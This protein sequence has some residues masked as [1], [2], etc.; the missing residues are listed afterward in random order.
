[1]IGFLNFSASG[2]KARPAYSHCDKDRCWIAWNWLL[3]EMNLD[4]Y[5]I[6]LGET[7]IKCL[8][9]T[10]FRFEGQYLLILVVMLV[11]DNV[12]P[13]EEQSCDVILCKD[14]NSWTWS[15]RV[16]KLAAIYSC[17][18]RDDWWD[19]WTW[20]L[21]DLK[22]GDR[23]LSSWRGICWNTWSKLLLHLKLAT[24]SLSLWPRWIFK[25]LKLTTVGSETPYLSAF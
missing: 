12:L 10:V 3:F 19:A 15:W 21:L 17:P 6:S 13:S 14:F 1:M 8:N 2:S 25:S 23:S 7:R 22:L 11:N 4:L 9:L 18:D 16:L 20:P 5:P 24:C